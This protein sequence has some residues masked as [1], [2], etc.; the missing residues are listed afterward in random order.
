MT[1]LVDAYQRDDIHQYEKILQSNKDDILSDPFI[2]ENID[3]VTR[4][5]RTKALV[6]LISPFTRFTLDFIATQ[7]KISIHE[8]QEILGFLILDQKIRGKINQENGT[9][10][11][12]S[13]SDVERMESMR[14]WSSAIGSLW[15]TVFG[16]GDGFKSSD[17]SSQLVQGAGMSHILQTFA[18]GSGGQ[19]GL[20]RA[21]A[22][23]K[24]KGMAGKTPSAGFK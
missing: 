24:G 3:E 10:E 14:Q 19:G 17:D 23:S 6:K 12:E 21:K 1:D 15:N 13:K 22:G 7:L 4:N 5:M 20:G 18:E 11:I 16:E 2:A 9:V 8:V